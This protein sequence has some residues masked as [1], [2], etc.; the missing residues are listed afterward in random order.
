M[1][2]RSM[3]SFDWAMKRLLRNKTN[4]VVLEGFQDIPGQMH[5]HPAGFAISF[6]SAT[7]QIQ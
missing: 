5:L 1:K 2:T 6:I 7:K 3:V 4:F